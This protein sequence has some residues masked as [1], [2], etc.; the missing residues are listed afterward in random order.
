M[1]LMDAH[2]EASRLDMCLRAVA[3]EVSRAA[4]I[5]TDIRHATLPLLLGVETRLSRLL[6][7]TDS[8][9]SSLKP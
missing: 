4:F 8:K 2:A 7:M 6:K 3:A 9:I 1:Q 5:T